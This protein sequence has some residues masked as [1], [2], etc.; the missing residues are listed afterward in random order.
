MILCFYLLSL[1][2][3]NDHSVKIFPSLSLPQPGL[4]S[5]IKIFHEIS[6]CLQSSETL[7]DVPQLPGHFLCPH[8]GKCSGGEGRGLGVVELELDDILL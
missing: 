6:H 8:M 5:G 4:G 2:Q 7:A 1:T 3:L